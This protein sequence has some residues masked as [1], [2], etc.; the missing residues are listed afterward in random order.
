MLSLTVSMADTIEDPIETREKE[1]KDQPH[2]KSKLGLVCSCLGCVVGTGNIWRFPRIVANNSEDK[3]GLVFLIV[4]VVFLFLWSSPMLLIEYGTGRFT[5]KAIIGSFRSILGDKAAWLG[6][7]ITMV[8]FL[9]SC[10]YSVVLGWCFYYVGYCMVNDLPDESEESTKIFQD[11]A[12]ESYWPVLTHAMALLTAGFAVIKGVKTFE[13]VNMVLVPILL[14]IVLFTFIWSLTREYAD[15]GI[16]FLFT[17]DWDSF[18]KPRLWVDAISQ[19]AFDTGAGMGLFIPYAS[20]MTR[21]HAIVK[22]GTLIPATNNIVS[23]ICGMM[24]F[25]TVFSTLIVNRPSLGRS[26]IVTILKTSGPA[27]TGLTFIWIPVLF[28]TMGTF[29]QV[30]CVLFFLCLSFAGVTSLIANME[31]VCHTLEDFGIPRKY[32]MPGTVLVAFGIGAMSAVNVNILTN[33][34]FVWAFGL[35]ING[36]MLQYLVIR[37][38]ISKFRNDVFNYYSTDDWTLPSIWKWIVL[39]VA[40]LEATAILIWWAV[41][42]IQSEEDTG[43][44]WYEFGTE[45][46]MVTLVQWAILMLAVILIN[47]MWLYC[48]RLYGQPEERV[49]LL[50]HSVKKSGEWHN[51]SGN[52]VT[53]ADTDD[54]TVK[55][56]KL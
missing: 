17:P 31:L 50:Q 3:G 24:I 14:V 10:Y 45:T 28:A 36:L 23:L 55:D 11:Y 15:Y 38:G 56:V 46:L 42:L 40:P 2:F 22:Y 20:F 26:D 30:L 6:A 21:D 25:S 47:M 54:T 5:K 48:R 51:Y 49:R 53:V 1:S 27:S 39:I 16:K 34:D 33:Q 43:E 29:G 19:N 18:A 7:W 12:E 35:L 9:I 37:Y 13:K 32:G 4:W 8:T 44:K 52:N 41:D